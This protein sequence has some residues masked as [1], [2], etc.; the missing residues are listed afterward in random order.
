[1]TKQTNASAAMTAAVLAEARGGTF[2]GLIIRKKGVQRGSGS[3]KQT[4]GDDMVHVVLY[5][6]FR[7]ETLVQRSLDALQEMDPAALVS[8]F[9]KRGITDG[10]GNAIRLADVCT[11]IRD[12]DDSFQKSLA[13]TN[14][15]TTDHVF[16]PLV[17]DGDVVRGARVYKCVAS[18]PTR[19]CHCRDCTGDAK[20]PVDGQI[21][22]SGLKIGEKV[23]D[24]AP[25]GPIPPS[26]SRAD[27]V[28]KN[29]IRSRLPIGRYVSYVLEKNGD[30]VLNAGGAAAMACDTNG[31]TLDPAR[32]Q[33]AAEYLTASG[34]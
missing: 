24:P 31:V 22:L 17:V 6:G 8:E 32:V 25:N 9:A 29:V 11:A 33:A 27:V 14:S 13:G 10:H 28:A 30:Y 4:Y 19:K 21:N 2:S 18:D 5:T 26:K 23:I 12:L 34:Q 15:S 20:A 16:E 3:A 7:Y 1:M